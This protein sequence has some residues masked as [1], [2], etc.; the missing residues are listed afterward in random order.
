[1]IT[2]ESQ[3]GKTKFSILLPINNELIEKGE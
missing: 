3:S 1:M 2:F